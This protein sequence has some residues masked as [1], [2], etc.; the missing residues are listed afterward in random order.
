MTPWERIIGCHRERQL[1]DSVINVLLDL[2]AADSVSL[3]KPMTYG[4][5][6]GYLAECWNEGRL[7]EAG[8]TLDDLAGLSWR[9]KHL[10][11]VQFTEMV[12]AYLTEL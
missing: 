2:E 6:C 11:Q 5:L 8:Y 1:F 7:V 3:P 9:L 4:W 10:S 12:K